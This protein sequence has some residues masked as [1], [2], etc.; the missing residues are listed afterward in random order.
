MY[1]SSAVW[2]IQKITPRLVL[3]CMKRRP[4][5]LQDYVY[6]IEADFFIVISPQS[7]NVD[8]KLWVFTTSDITISTQ[9]LSEPEIVDHAIEENK[10]SFIEL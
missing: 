7:L 10:S 3:A 5:V 2:A 4:E 8:F 6:I 1:K 9:A